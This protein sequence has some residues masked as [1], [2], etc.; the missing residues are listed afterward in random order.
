[1]PMSALPS[2]SKSNAVLRAAGRLAWLTR[3]L[4]PPIRMAPCLASPGLGATLYVK[5]P[6]PTPVAP[7]ITVM[8]AFRRRASYGQPAVTVRLTTRLSAPSAPTLT[9]AGS[10]VTAHAMAPNPTL[11]L[12][13]GSA[14]PAPNESANATRA[15]A[16]KRAETPPVPK[17]MMFV[18]IGLSPLMNVT[19]PAGAR[20]P[21]APTPSTP[22][23][24]PRGHRG[25]ARRTE[26]RSPGHHVAR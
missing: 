26:A 19:M 11:P 9:L 12:L 23:A 13:A 7:A 18:R 5:A 24:R 4:V 10:R 2:P 25:R 14:A 21:R 16:A 3:N 17:L 6:L 8:N 20:P 22:S 15:T 1:M